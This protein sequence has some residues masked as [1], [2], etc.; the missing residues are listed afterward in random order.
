MP[1][2]NTNLNAEHIAYMATHTTPKNAT[3][4]GMLACSASAEHA[5][6]VGDEARAVT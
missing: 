1:C 6:C 4:P 3:K 5:S 2:A